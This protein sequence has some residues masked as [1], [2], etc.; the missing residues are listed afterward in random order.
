[1]IPRTWYVY[2]LCHPVTGDVRYIG[3]SCN[4]VSRLAEHLR[5]S[6]GSPGCPV[7]NWVS[8]LKSSPEVKILQ[9]CRSREEARSREE[10]FISE[11]KKRFDLLNRNSRFVF[12]NES[13]LTSGV[14]CR[15]RELRISKNLSRRALW[16]TSG[17][18]L[19]TIQRVEFGYDLALDRRDARKLARALGTTVEYLVTGESPSRDSVAA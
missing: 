3:Q 13:A 1:M 9:E 18:K 12:V 7:N 19:E 8:S 4:L 16:L 10:W 14:A 11:Y 15:L 5:P 6:P 17:V 2:A